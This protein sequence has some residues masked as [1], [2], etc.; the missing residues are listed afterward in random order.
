MKEKLLR[1]CYEGTSVLVIAT[2]IIAIMFTFFVRFIS[3]VGDSMNDTLASGNWVIVSEMNLNYEPNYGDIVIISQPNTMNENLIKRVIATE[4]QQV[5]INFQTGAVFIDGHEII[6][7][8][9]STP[10]TNYFDISFPITVPA[11]YCFVMGDNRQNSVDSR[12]SVV[13]LIDNRYVL[14]NAVYAIT[15][16]GFKNLDLRASN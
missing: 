15:S 11:G 3:V 14:G 8:Y 4:G 16:D 6:E 7:S 5:N 13:G 1:V 12:S 10:T 2:V 9:I